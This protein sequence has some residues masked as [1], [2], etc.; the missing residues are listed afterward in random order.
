M[1]KYILLTAIGLSLGLN[2]MMAQTAPTTEHHP[3]IR[4]AITSLENAKGYL[5]KASHDFGGHRAD[6]LASVEV[7]LKQLRLALQYDKN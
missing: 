3:A 6:A 1:K 7:A 5:Q 4:H 2:S